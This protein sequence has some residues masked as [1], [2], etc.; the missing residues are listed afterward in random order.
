MARLLQPQADAA[1]NRVGRAC[2]Q[3]WEDL[4]RDSLAPSALNEG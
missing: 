2:H 4:P 3:T 1:R